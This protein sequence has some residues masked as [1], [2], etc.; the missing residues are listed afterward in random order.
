MDG[1]TLVLKLGSE[2]T[3]RAVIATDAVTTTVEVARQR[4]HSNT[5]YT[6]K[7]IVHFMF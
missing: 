5:S 4:T 2:R 6:K 3:G 1:N 7:I